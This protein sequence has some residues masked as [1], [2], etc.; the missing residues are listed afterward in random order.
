MQQSQW[1]IVI[2]KPTRVFLN[3]LA[4]QV[5]EDLLPDYQTLLVDKTAYVIRKQ[6]DDEATLDEIEQHFT[7]MFRHEIQRWLGP[8]ASNEIEYSF[9]DFLCCFKFELHD[10]IVL[11]ESDFN[12]AKQLLTIKPR[13]VLLKWMKSK[14]SD[15]QELTTILEDVSLNNIS[16]NATVVVKNFSELSQIKPFVK[17]YYLPVYEAEMSRM[18]D[19]PEQWPEVDSFET[20][21]R[22]FAVE[23]HTQLIHLHH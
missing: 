7:T 15:N 4:T 10:H 8:E 11:M 17:D 2:L 22:Y 19:S 1:E 23:V 20:F 18:S 9:L 21:N 12:Q 3:F 14:V 5:E 6:E 13:N 16:E